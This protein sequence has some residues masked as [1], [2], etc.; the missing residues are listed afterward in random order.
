MKPPLRQFVLI[1][2][3][4]GDI[5][6]RGVHHWDGVQDYLE[7]TGYVNMGKV[8]VVE[9]EYHWVSDIPHLINTDC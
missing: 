6:L 7:E 9:R 1:S 3:S 4:L 8:K 2:P 5:I